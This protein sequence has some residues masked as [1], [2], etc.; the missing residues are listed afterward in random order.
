MGASLQQ[1]LPPKAVLHVEHKG[2]RAISAFALSLTAPILGVSDISLKIRVI[3]SFH[4]YPYI[5]IPRG[6]ALDPTILPAMVSLLN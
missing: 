2:P 6:L 5:S 4:I 1:D 3:E